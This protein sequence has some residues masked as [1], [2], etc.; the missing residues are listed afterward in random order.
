M[1]I[2]RNSLK[3][4]LKERIVSPM[5]LSAW[6]ESICKST[7]HLTE[8]LEVSTKVRRATCQIRFFDSCNRNVMNYPCSSVPQTALMEHGHKYLHGGMVYTAVLEA[9]LRG[10]SSNL[11]GGT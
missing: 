6:P 10:L 8:E 3:F 2:D 1:Y 9:V 4:R 7:N 5:L 11:S